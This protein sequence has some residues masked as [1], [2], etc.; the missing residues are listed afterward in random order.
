L[1]QRNKIRAAQRKSLR[2]KLPYAEYQVTEI[3]STLTDHKSQSI[4]TRMD[5]L[6]EPLRLPQTVAKY[7]DFG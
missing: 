1:S 7:S 5:F 4:E 2:C 3:Y 6:I